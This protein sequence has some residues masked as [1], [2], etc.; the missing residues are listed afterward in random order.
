MELFNT[1]TIYLSNNKHLNQILSSRLLIK[2]NKGLFL[3]LNYHF[4]L[5][6][7]F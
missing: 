3:K 6:L 5:I 2:I 4:S 7:N 1:M